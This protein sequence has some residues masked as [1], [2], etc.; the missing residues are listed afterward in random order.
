MT[1]IQLSFL[2]QDPLA[3]LVEAHPPLEVPDLKALP[4]ARRED[5]TWHRLRLLGHHLFIAGATG[6]GKGS[7]LWSIITQLSGGIRSGLVE[8]VGLDPKGGVE[9]G[10][11]AHLFKR[12]C[13]GEL[14][15]EGNIKSVEESFAVVLEHYVSVMRQR[16]ERMFARFRLH[17]PTVEEPYVVIVIDEMAALVAKAYQSD[18]DAGKRVVAA[19]NIL[20]SQGRAMGITIVGAVQDPRKESVPMRGLFTTRI[21]LRLNEQADVDLVLGDGARA[22]GAWCDKIRADRQGTGYAIEETAPDPIRLRFPFT[23]DD[24]IQHLPA[25]PGRLRAAPVQDQ[26]QDLVPADSTTEAAVPSWLPDEFKKEGDA[27]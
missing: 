18:Q 5:G 26:V 21:A 8:L 6:A 15:A 13:R 14:D 9:L 1:E 24:E 10:M 25:A 3:D 2:H 20:L 22:R 27:A 11:G 17:K 7:V 23:T 12:F 4:I 16:Q 19:I